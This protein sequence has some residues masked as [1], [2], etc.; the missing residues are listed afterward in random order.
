MAHPKRRQSKSRTLR[1]RGH[2][3]VAMPQLA[4]D[5]ESGAWH[6][7]HTVS[8]DSGYYR[9]KKVFEVEE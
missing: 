5:P 3:G 6:I 4:R 2:D 7:A 1:R 9:G 8:P